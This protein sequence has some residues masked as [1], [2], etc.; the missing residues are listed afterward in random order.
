MNEQN[1]IEITQLESLPEYLSDS[2]QLSKL[3]EKKLKELG[4][5]CKMRL[6]ELKSD[7]RMSHWEE[8]KQA[9]FDSFHLV[10]PKKDLPYAGYPNLACPLARIGIDTFHANFLYTFGGDSGEFHVLPDYLSKSHMD[11]AD[12]AAQYMSYVLN[13]EADFYDALDKAGMDANKYKVGYMKAFYLKNQEW[14]TRYV[15]TEESVP[16]V[17]ELTGD[18]TPKKVK[19]RKKERVKK[20]LFDGV[21]VRRVSPES[22]FVSP[23]FETTADAVEKDY[24]FEVNNYNMRYIT[25]LSKSVDSDIDPYFTESQVKKI[26]AVKRSEIVAN[27]ERNKQEYD[28]YQVDCKVDLLPIEL[29]EA[30]FKEDLNDD[31]LSE[32]V[33]VVFETSTGTVL[34]VSYAK[35]RI[36]KLC[37]RPV[38]GR[39]DGES[40]RQAIQSLINE[41]E[42]IHNQR[43]AKGQWSNLPFMLYKAGGRFNPQTI[44]LMPGKAYPVDDPA[45]VAFPQPPSPDMSYF[46][47][48]KLLMDLVDRV[49]ALGDVIQGVTNSGD[50]ATETIHSQQRAGIRLATPINRMAKAL[51]ELMGHIWELNKQCAPEIK[52]FQIVGMG[53]GLPVFEKITSKDYDVMVN[54]KLKMAT[55]QETQ[56]LRDT[57]LLNYKTFISNPLV[58]QN[59]ASFYE[60]TKNTMD[61]VGLKINLPKPD[62]AKV[63]SPW[64]IIDM[65]RAGSDDMEPII[66]TDADEHMKAVMAFMKSED[67][68]NWPTDRQQQLLLYYDK[69]QILK[70][71]LESG[72]LNQSGIFAGPN[73]TA[74]GSSPAMTATRN[75]SQTFNN[76]RVG[77]TGNSQRQQPMNGMK[78][79]N[80]G[81]Y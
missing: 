29:A 15:T 47:E 37:P 5:K 70:Q 35:C 8:D 62:Q 19:R 9:D 69:L 46:Q 33:S 66:G 80:N 68:E 71:T 48:E 12:R 41:W 3:G 25:E 73:P 10:P 74:G 52:E 18:I 56:I 78:G 72:N 39:W 2:A 76:L 13:Y 75:P 17:N 38:D 57:A 23:F 81:G 31:G 51:N 61:A 63:L 60:L 59:P 26:K 22:V 7:R 77:E 4:A 30:H 34:R 58:M 79:A 1:S 14:E 67:Y 24:L 6:D 53:N 65:I 32:K 49:L 11:V 45:S 54:F 28:G 16:E 40:V 20:T 64:V 36:V 50:T 44:T 21:K 42:A 43:V 27:Y 55:L